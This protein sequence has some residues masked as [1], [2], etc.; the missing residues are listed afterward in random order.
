MVIKT[1]GGIKMVIQEELK[2]KIIE[3]V[4]QLKEFYDCVGI[5]IGNNQGLFI[6]VVND[7][8]GEKVYLLELNDIYEDNEW[9]PITTNISS[10]GN[11]KELIKEIKAVM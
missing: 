10:F 3:E 9:C 4:K 6:Q 1:T 11:M 7:D 5:N 2:N 8:D